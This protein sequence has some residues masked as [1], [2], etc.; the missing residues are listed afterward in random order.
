MG[1]DTIHEFMSQF[2]F[3][4]NF[5]LDIAYARTGVLPSK[6]WKRESRGEPWYPGATINSS[7]G[8]GY[9]WAT[10]L[11]LATAA[12]IVANKGKVNKPRMLKS[13]DGK[14]YDPI[15]E[16]ELPDVFVK[17]PDYWRYI[18]TVSYTHLTLPT[19]PYV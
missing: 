9:M 5:A 10:P 12:S 17:D 1:I 11:Q 7:I 18:E 4:Q 6:D 16:T 13:V 19:T 15:I 8:Q 2:G 14:P 3:G